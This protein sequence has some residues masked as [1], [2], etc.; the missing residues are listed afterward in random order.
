MGEKALGK[1]MRKVGK[2]KKVVVKVVKYFRCDGL[3]VC[4]AYNCPRSAVAHAAQVANQ[5]AGGR[6][7]ERVKAIGRSLNL[8]FPIASEY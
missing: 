1:N 4:L 6:P 7:G 2:E 8:I 5:R 3:F